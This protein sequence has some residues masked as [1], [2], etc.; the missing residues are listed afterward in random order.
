MS[1]NA[2][3]LKPYKGYTGN[4]ELDF[5]HRLYY[6]FI[7][8][9]PMQMMFESP[10]LIGLQEDFESCV[11]EYIRISGIEE[12]ITMIENNKGELDKEVKEEKNIVYWN[13]NG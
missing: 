11:D 7:Q 10:T 2:T 6:G 12:T 1:L 8:D 13:N 9:I 3:K 5:E 4:I